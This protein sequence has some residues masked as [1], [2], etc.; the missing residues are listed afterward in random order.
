MEALTAAKLGFSVFAYQRLTILGC[1]SQFIELMV[2]V[3]A[4]LKGLYGH[5]KLVIFEMFCGV[6]DITHGFAR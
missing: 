5:P 2:L 4:S 3:R 1:P 6:A